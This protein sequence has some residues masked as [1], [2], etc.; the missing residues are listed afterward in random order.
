MDFI[1]TEYD[2]ASGRLTVRC[3]GDLDMQTVPSLT[4]VTDRE[5]SEH[6]PSHLVFDF[7]GLTFLDSTGLGM[8]VGYRSEGRT[9]GFSVVLRNLRPRLHRLLVLTAL[10]D[11]FVI[12]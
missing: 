9:Q 6:R 11:Q 12:E 10:V 7:A 2:V 8:L 3:V 5:L 4:A 1:D